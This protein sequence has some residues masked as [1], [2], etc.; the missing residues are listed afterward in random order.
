MNNNF[1]IIMQLREIHSMRAARV[2]CNVCIV[3]HYQMLL[4]VLKLTKYPRKSFPDDQ[5]LRL[6]CE[7]SS[8]KNYFFPFLNR[9]NRAG[10][11]LL[12]YS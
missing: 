3:V 11:L 9:V 5:S 10:P 7:Y 12:N 8:T 6:R 2:I 1:F 4:K